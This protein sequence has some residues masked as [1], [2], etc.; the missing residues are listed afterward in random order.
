MFVKFAAKLQLFFDIC[1]KKS[2]FFALFLTLAFGYWLLA[3][4]QRLTTN[5]LRPLYI[6]HCPFV[7]YIELS[8]T[9][10]LLTSDI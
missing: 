2:D 8:V 7:H 9:E 1:K 3:N 10:E 5:D 4:D 6:V